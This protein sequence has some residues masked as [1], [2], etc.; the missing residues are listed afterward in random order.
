MKESKPQMNSPITTTYKS[1]VK[2]L[3]IILPSSATHKIIVRTPVSSSD[4]LSFSVFKN[5]VILLIIPRTLS[6]VVA[7]K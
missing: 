2:R 7:C 4:N 3:L 1:L 6:L 5:A